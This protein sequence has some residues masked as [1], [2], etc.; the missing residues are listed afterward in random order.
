[1]TFE[2]FATETLVRERP[3][4]VDNGHGG[5]EDD[6]SE[7]DTLELF[8]SV[9]PGASDEVLQN[10]DGTLIQWTVY[11]DGSPDVLSTDRVQYNG[12][13]YAIDGE[14]AGWN[15]PIDIL[16][17]RVLLLKRWEG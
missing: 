9:D 14:P 1:M 10:R 12:H 8:G 17:H 15:S 7:P 6:W 5:F 2:L 4:R 11:L 16:D 13:T 3:R